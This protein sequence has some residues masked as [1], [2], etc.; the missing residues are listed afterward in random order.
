M[1]KTKYLFDLPR[2]PEDPLWVFKNC[3]DIIYDR[4]NFLSAVDLIVKKNGFIYEGSYCFFP[5]MDDYDEELHFEGV[6]FVFGDYEP[7]EKLMVTEQQ[8]FELVK[9]ACEKYVSKH[10][11]DAE[12]VQNILA[13]SILAK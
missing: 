9:M 6:M 8:C 1:N 2:E 7:E 3:F 4:G 5:D 12:K 11:E 13:E 10:P